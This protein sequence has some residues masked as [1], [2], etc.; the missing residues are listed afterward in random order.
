MHLG[1]LSQKKSIGK[2]LGD[3]ILL[4]LWCAYQKNPLEKWK[5]ELVL[6]YLWDIHQKVS[7][8]QRVS[9]GNKSLQY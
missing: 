2:G 1:F 6:L 3:L 4:Y 8:F 9:L 7:F 5:K